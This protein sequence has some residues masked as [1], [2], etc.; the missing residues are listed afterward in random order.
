MVADRRG[1][2]ATILTP[3]ARHGPYAVAL[4]W[5]IPVVFASWLLLA[6]TPSFGF[7]AGLCLPADIG[8][9]GSL[10]ANLRAQ[11]ALTEPLNWFVEWLLMIGAM[12]LPFAIPALSFLARGSFAKRRARSLALWLVGFLAA[13]ALASAMASVLILVLRA[14][15]TTLEMT[16]WSAI[17]CYAAAAGWQLSAAKRS[18]LILCHIKPPVRAFGFAADVDAIGFGAG[19]GWRCCCTC[20]PVMALAMV[21]GQWTIEMFVI[22]A[23]LLAERAVFR[24]DRRL[25]VVTAGILL[26]LGLVK[27]FHSGGAGAFQAL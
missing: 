7:V 20:L 3:I 19:H 14:L 10:A 26:A 8:T 21:A 9:L 12:M 2:G 11:G 22:F 5:T 18:A 1:G 17:V 27:S 16:S 6:T 15:F 25:M 4:R 13:W 23:I 24:P